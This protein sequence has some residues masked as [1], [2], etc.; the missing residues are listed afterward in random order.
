[1]E[2]AASGRPGHGALD[3]PAVPPQPLRGFHALAGQAMDDSAFTQP[4]AQ[5][6]VVVTF[7]AVE[8]A[9]FASPAASPG[10]DGRYHTNQRLQQVRTR[11]RHPGPI[12]DQVDRGALLA[13]DR[14]DSDPSD[15]PFESTHVDRVDRAPRPVQLTPG[16][17]FAQDQTVQLRPHAGPT[18]LGETPMCGRP[19]GAE[20]RWELAQVQPVVAT[21]MIAANTSRSPCL[22]RPPP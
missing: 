11:D 9:G 6:V 22:R 18:P 4:S 21:K 16:T 10:L 7:V 20:H 13:P 2:T 19:G 12:G 5:V 1:M 17:E 3:L 8:L 14:Q 15:P